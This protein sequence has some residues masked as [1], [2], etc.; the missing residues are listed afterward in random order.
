MSVTLT[1]NDVTRYVDAV[2]EALSDLPAAQ[3]DELLDDLTQHL[4]EVA[5]EGDAPLS[6]RLGPPAAYAEELRA[7]IGLTADSP[8]PRGGVLHR[9]EAGLDRGR[10]A[11]LEHPTSR[12]V[13][14]FL[15]ELRPGWWVLRGYLLVA[16][17]SVLWDY[18]G[19]RSFP[20]PIVYGS[21]VLGLLATLAAI[22]ASVAIG[23]GTVRGPHWRRLVVVGNTL[24]VLATLVASG[25]GGPIPRRQVMPSPRGR[26]ISRPRTVRRSPTSSRTGRTGG[27]CPVSGCMTRA[28][29]RSATS[30]TRRTAVTTSGA[31]RRT[32]R[33]AKP[34]MPFR[35]CGRPL[36][37]TE[38]RCP[39]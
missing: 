3:R 8:R 2:R 28:G 26:P 39:E 24:L 17:P 30:A 14:D 11:L 21:R 7:S 35:C 12:A 37:R 32:P 22:V 1:E 19:A 18:A 31:V 38:H 4:Q 9:L 34:P 29:G 13:V 36:A 20:W 5:A 10:A 16:V 23:R 25:R 6:V 15:P 27:R 33:A